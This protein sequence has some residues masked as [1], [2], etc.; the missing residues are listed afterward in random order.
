MIFD[1]IL[2]AYYMIQKN[3]IKVLGKSNFEI[4]W[5]NIFFE[6]YFFSL[7]KNNNCFMRNILKNMKTYEGAGAEALC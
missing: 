6:N 7:E 5:K 1:N 3:N 4:L 2:S